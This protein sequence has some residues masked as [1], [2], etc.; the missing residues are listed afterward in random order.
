MPDRLRKRIKQA[1]W[2]DIL[3]DKPL[4]I[5]QPVE[6]CDCVTASLCLE[7]ACGSVPSYIKVK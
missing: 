1:I 4:G 2:C 3:Q 7:S 6:W 5:E